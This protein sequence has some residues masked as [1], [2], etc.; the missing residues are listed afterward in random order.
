MAQTDPGP[1]ED[2]DRAFATPIFAIVVL[3]S[4]TS[5]IVDSIAFERFGV[6]V[7]NQTGNLVVIALSLAGEQRATTL[8]AC[9]I[10]L[11]SFTAGVFIAILM[12]RE[13]RKRFGIP[14]ARVLTLAIESS[15]I[16]ITSIGVFVWGTATFAYAAVALLS[17]SQAFQA[18]V[19]TRIVGIVLQTVVINAALVQS[20][21][22]WSTGRR[23]AGAIAFG[24]PIGYLL[25]AFAGALLMRSSVHAALF[26]AVFTAAAATV[27]AYR[28]EVRG[29]T[30]E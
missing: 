10:A 4:A 13:M 11:V 28:I 5:G 16:A 8:T 18:A 27:I 29:A 17:L 30:I 21:E 7:A 3:L 9:A 24:T 14:R 1:G 12:R 22:A 25:G 6:F 19:V 15:L 26:S 2:V 20:A 23:R